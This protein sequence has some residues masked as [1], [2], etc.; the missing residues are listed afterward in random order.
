MWH[1]ELEVAKCF[2]LRKLRLHL[3]GV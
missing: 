1:L 3:Q 2:R